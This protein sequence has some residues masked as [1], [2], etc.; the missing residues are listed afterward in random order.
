[1]IKDVYQSSQQGD[2]A[3]GPSE[4]RVA[5]IN[6]YAIEVIFTQ[7]GDNGFIKRFGSLSITH[8]QLFRTQT[9]S[10]I[11]TPMMIGGKYLQK[12]HYFQLFSKGVT[13]T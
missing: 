5:P 4:S 6:T 1:M 7:R 9:H 12:N 8:I 3:N 11:I 13:Q 2:G 10:H